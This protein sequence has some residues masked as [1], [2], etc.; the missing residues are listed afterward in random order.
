MY[1]IFLYMYIVIY[2]IFHCNHMPNNSEI[3]NLKLGW[4]KKNERWLKK[5]KKNQHNAICK[6]AEQLVVTVPTQTW[7]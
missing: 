3:T 5:D 4:K 2:W 6:S 1:A 7:R